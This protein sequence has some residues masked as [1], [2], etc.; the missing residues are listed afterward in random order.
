MRNHRYLSSPPRYK[1][2]STYK[3]ERYKPFAYRNLWSDFNEASVTFVIWSPS[4]FSD[5]GQQSLLRFHLSHYTWI[6]CAKLRM[7]FFLLGGKTLSFSCIPCCCQ[8]ENISKNIRTPQQNEG[9]PLFSRPSGQSM[10]TINSQATCPQQLFSYNIIAEHWI[11]TSVSTC[12]AA[13]KIIQNNDKGSFSSSSLLPTEGP[14]LSPFM[15]WK[16][17]KNGIKNKLIV[18][19]SYGSLT[20]QPT[21]VQNGLVLL[22]CNYCCCQGEEN[23]ISH[24]KKAKS[25]KHSQKPKLQQ[26][27]CVAVAQ[28][29][30]L[31]GIWSFLL[32]WSRPS[33]YNFCL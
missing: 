24:Q 26:Q 19:K 25:P 14:I 21:A 15:Q 16:E 12:Y 11:R 18:L 9:L 32:Y 8:M 29:V 3:D 6:S 5:E 27:P 22:C 4:H 13:E 10:R 28:Q 1:S 7:S 30:R 20:N 23:F 2:A 31:T 33:L 17:A